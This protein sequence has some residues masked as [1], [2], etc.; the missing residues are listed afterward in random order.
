MFTR[1]RDVSLGGMYPRDRGN[2]IG[3]FCFVG[4]PTPKNVRPIENK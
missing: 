1:E 3:D 4:D 2:S